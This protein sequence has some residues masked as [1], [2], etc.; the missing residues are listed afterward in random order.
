VRTRRGKIVEKGG[1]LARLRTSGDGPD[2][3]FRA[4]LRERLMA[5][6]GG[7]GEDHRKDNHTEAVE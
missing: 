3:R 6:A 2:P 7:H 4:D 1:A 5:A